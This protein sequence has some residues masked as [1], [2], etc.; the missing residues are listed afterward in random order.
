MIL[1]KNG[2]NSTTSSGFVPEFPVFE[3]WKLEHTV[4]PLSRIPQ[5]VRKKDQNV[6]CNIF[7][8]TPAILIKFD[9]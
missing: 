3:D 9:G 5:C 2:I 1:T 8:K 4:K 6:F 7:Y